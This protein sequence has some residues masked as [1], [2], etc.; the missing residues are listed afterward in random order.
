M[1]KLYA[2]TGMTIPSGMSSR[3]VSA[4]FISNAP[5][6]TFQS[7]FEIEGLWDSSIRKESITMATAASV[8]GVLFRLSLKHSM[9]VFYTINH[10]FP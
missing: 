3:T 2:E 7:L 10:S 6:G 8:E 9:S 5:P 1:L 4:I